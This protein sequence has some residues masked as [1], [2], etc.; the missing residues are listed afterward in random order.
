MKKS[1]KLS[2]LLLSAMAM[3]VGASCTD[4]KS[5]T[6]SNSTTVS[7]TT[8]VAPTTSVD[9]TTI[10]P[11]TTVVQTTN[12]TTTT[13]PTQT[14]TTSP[15]TT[16]DNVVMVS[17]VTG[18]NVLK[19]VTVN[20]G[21]CVSYDEMP[22]DK[23]GYRNYYFSDETLTTVF[24]FS[25]PVTTNV[26]VYVEE[27]V[28]YDVTYVGYDGDDLMTKM[29]KYDTQVLPVLNRI[30][31]EGSWYIDGNK[32]T[33]VSN[34]SGNVT[35]EARYVANT[36]RITYELSGG[37][38]AASNPRTI[39]VEDE[40]TLE[41][42]TRTGY[43][44]VGWYLNGEEV[45]TLKGITSNITLVAK[46]EVSTVDVSFK[47]MAGNDIG[48]VEI[49]LGDRL[50]SDISLNIPTDVNYKLY[51]V[52]GDELDEFNVNTKI[53][54]AMTIYVDYF[55]GTEDDYSV[56]LSGD[57]VYLTKA[58]SDYEVLYL[59]MFV[60]GSMVT[61]TY[62]A[63][64]ND[65]GLF[66][67]N[68]N[69]KEVYVPSSYRS[70]G[71]KTFA[72]MPNLE[73]VYF[74]DTVDY[75]VENA[76]SETNV[77]LVFSKDNFEAMLE[78]TNVS[79]TVKL[80]MSVAGMH[81]VNFYDTDGNMI[82]V[83]V[84]ENGGT[85]EFPTATVTV[86]YSFDGWY[87]NDNK[88]DEDYQFNS[89]A[90]V[91]ARQ[92]AIVV[93]VNYVLDGGET[94]NPTTFTVE[95]GVITLSD[96]YKEGVTFAGWY[97]NADL[98]GNRVVAVSYDEYQSDITLY[99][100]FTAEPVVITLYGFDNEISTINSTKNSVIDLPKYYNIEGVVEEWYVK[101]GDE[102]QLFDNSTVI[103]ADM[104][105]YLN[106]YVD[107]VL[108]IVD[109]VVTGNNA[110]EVM[111]T[112]FIP[113]IYDGVL[114]TKIDDRALYTTGGSYSTFGFR[115]VYISRA[116]DIS[117]NVFS[118]PLSDYSNA[119]V[120]YYGNEVLT[121]QMYSM[122]SFVEL[123]I[124]DIDGLYEAMSSKF[125]NLVS[126]NHLYV[127]GYNKIL[128]KYSAYQT[129]GAIDVKEGMP[130]TEDQLMD[131]LTP[132]LEQNGY[133]FDG[134]FT[135][136][137]YTTPYDFTT[138][139]DANASLYVRYIRQITIT[140]YE[141]GTY[142]SLGSVRT[143]KGNT[144]SI[145]DILASLDPTK[146]YDLYS[147]GYNQN[148]E[149][150]YTY[151]DMS[152]P[153]NQDY[154]FSLYIKGY[155]KGFEISEGVIT[156]YTGTDTAIVVPDTV[157]GQ[158][159][160]GIAEY[161]FDGM[162]NVESITLPSSITTIGD[163]AFANMPNLTKVTINATTAP[164]LGENV[165]ENHN[166]SLEIE[167]LP[168]S[169][170]YD[171]G[172][173]TQF[174]EVTYVV[175]FSGINQ[176]VE[177]V[178]KSGD[179]V[180]Q[181]ED[182]VKTNAKFLYWYYYDETNTEQEFDF[183][184]PITNN[185]TIYAKF[186]YAIS[187][188]VQLFDGTTKQ[189]AKYA[190]E[191]LTEEDLGIASGMNYSAFLVTSGSQTTYEQIELPYDIVSSVNYIKIMVQ[192]E[193]AGLTIENGVVTGYTGTDT[194]VYVPVVS[195]GT[196]V[197]SVGDGA[198]ANT[199]VEYV[200]FTN[201]IKSFGS[202]VFE[203]TPELKKIYVYGYSV[204]SIQSDTFEG[205]NDTWK[206]QLPAN[207]SSSYESDSKWQAYSKHFAYTYSVS[208]NIADNN[209]QNNYQSLYIYVQDDG[210]I[211]FSNISV[212]DYSGNE[213]SFTSVNVYT[214]YSHQNEITLTDGVLQ[215]SDVMSSV[216]YGYIYLYIVINL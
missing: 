69:I 5:T 16:V 6:T 201:S 72:N 89:S 156:G 64:G 199:A 41:P 38:N 73:A 169:S 43:K 37:M 203:N 183:N 91:Y 152:I 134:V 163:Y 46:F 214:D 132:I 36:Y 82:S 17:F 190:G 86:G 104:E 22:I 66:E 39:T 210:S 110:T 80:A 101:A 118:M 33:E 12:P 129:V 147:Q 140:I 54:A 75:F 78:N 67:G 179:M 88:I 155:Q 180:E 206:V 116:I 109:G 145:D 70:I 171:Q 13:V 125:T 193:T 100:K 92:N 25:K 44:F 57:R 170:G 136:S 159:I 208:I 142:N 112:L 194:T 87:V 55:T 58:P 76:I 117:N 176:P 213:V 161:A 51:Y 42:A 103:N 98:T 99:A 74:T 130:I 124:K 20:K 137:A 2:L 96:A 93:N 106:V 131:M 107:G 128:I 173:W 21:D 27:C 119:K 47:D 50:P 40:V 160:T 7:P 167:T 197:T 95:D 182:P 120:Y 9:S 28:V 205:A 68:S 83:K 61:D 207:G 65:S 59:P 154:D 77:S 211:D 8:T 216:S 186:E 196:V 81:R 15:T 144:F 52:I 56:S 175:T 23:T 60:D 133:I 195:N 35:V 181:P 48:S 139:L 165:F 126:Q 202:K 212:K 94:T 4:N 108:N 172:D 90:D 141:Y 85:V 187:V 115:N 121:G 149:T 168:G 18:G 30:G 143:T 102:Y 14:T 19:S 32:V 62:H 127:E 174:V 79:D 200:Y 29:T 185:V 49:D 158:T 146:D 24:D 105:L 148:Y 135:D 11:T 26:T 178:V 45:T 138:A 166:T 3:L 204:V 189:V 157:K 71:A 188:S 111:D 150:V 34:V 209:G 113:W 63:I 123:Y 191:T 151:Y 184:T 114:V 162:E 10:V 53:N 192:Y 84:T 153:V 31:Y 164:T 215:I 177:V 198:F 1:F 97:L 122:G